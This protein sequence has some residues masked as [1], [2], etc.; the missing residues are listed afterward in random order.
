MRDVITA[1]GFLKAWKR[2]CQ[3]NLFAGNVMQG[4]ISGLQNKCCSG[5][6]TLPLKIL[7]VKA[8]VAIVI[9][10]MIMLNMEKKKQ[11]IKNKWITRQY[12]N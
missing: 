3:T 6:T 9:Y 4:S 2:W 1:I 12:H 10:N 8:F 7:T 11:F 5:I